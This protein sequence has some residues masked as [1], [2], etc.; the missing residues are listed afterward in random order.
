VGPANLQRC[1]IAG[2]RSK[3]RLGKLAHWV[4][5]L[6]LL[7]ITLSCVVL[8]IMSIFQR[9]VHGMEQVLKEIGFALKG[10]EAQTRSGILSLKSRE[11]I[12]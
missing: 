2:L 10:L 9:L 7:R 12:I 4:I 1:R 3:E 6:L 11:F 5:P 8:Y